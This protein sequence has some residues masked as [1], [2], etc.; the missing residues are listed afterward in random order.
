MTRALRVLH[1]AS[2]DLWAGAEAQTF[3]LISHLVR[4]PETEAAAVLM[5][6]GTLAEKL[7]SIGVSVYVSDERKAGLL[8]IL[9]FLRAVLRAWCPD[10]IHTHRQKENILGS[11]ANWSSQGVPCVRT[12]HGGKEHSGAKGWKGVH[13]RAVN[14]FD[15]WCGR[16]LQQKV[17]A[18]TEEL[19]ARI[20]ADFPAGKIEVIENGVDIETVREEKDVAE[21]RAAEPDAVHVG[22]AGRLAAVKRVDLFLEMAA[23]LVRTDPRRRWKFHIFGEGP[24]RPM[25]EELSKRERVSD[26][27]TF[28]GHR[29]DMSTCVGGLDVLVIC[30]DHEGMPMISLE[31]AALG[32]PTVGHAVGGLV[33]VVPREFL[34]AR[35]DAQGYGDGVLRA[36]RGDGLEIAGNHAAAVLAKF[37]AQRNA[38]RIRAMYECLV[39]KRN[40]R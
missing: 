26:N 25:L 2:G 40:V 19:G 21:F 16:A 29:R 8:R 17:I 20:A 35:H 32:V 1:V 27:V 18:V 30:S 31:A 4:M 11:L 24:M 13:Y 10:V 23:L 9:G 5:N 39:A 28:H 33:D 3:T 37:S 36:L 14:A 38:Q 22:I 15:R 6:E 12:V 7:R 34:V